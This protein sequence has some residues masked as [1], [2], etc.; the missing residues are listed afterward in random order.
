MAVYVNGRFLTEEPTGVQ[1]FAEQLV[2]GLGELRDDVVVLTPPGARTLRRA[3]IRVEAFGSG[4]A[5]KWEQCDLPARLRRAGSPLLVN[6]GNRA[7]LVYRHQISTL[8]DLLPMRFGDNFSLRFRLQFRVIAAVGVV[9]RSHRVLTV[10]DAAA[11]EIRAFYGLPESRT[12]VVHNA[13]DHRSDPRTGPGSSAIAGATP[14]VLA[15]GRAGRHRNAGVT[16]E[17]VGRL[18]ERTTL[19]LVLVGSPDPILMREAARLGDRCVFTGRVSDADLEA[20]YRGASCFVAPS[21]YEGFDI[22]PLEAQRAGAPVIASQ[23]DVHREVL[24]DA[25]LYFD[26]SDPDDLTQ[27]I[28]RVLAHPELRS[29]LIALGRENSARFDWGRSAAEL[30]RVIVETDA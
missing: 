23:I 26:P 8:H 6:L 7:P 22:P 20:L 16:I 18:L 11:A 5:F 24:R 15:F 1:R 12:A 25:A 13:V 4:N 10:S 30:N 27:Q 17:A 2:V 14:Y 21:L 3:N 9:R 19:R 29:R 28:E